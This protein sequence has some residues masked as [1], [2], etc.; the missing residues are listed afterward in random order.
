MNGLLGDKE[1]NGDDHQQ[2]NQPTAEELSL[3]PRS[4]FCA[5]N[6]LQDDDDAA[7]QDDG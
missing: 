4:F 1:R 3:R 5:R 6:N 7:K 2:V